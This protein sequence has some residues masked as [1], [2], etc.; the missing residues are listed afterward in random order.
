M[1]GLFNNL[2]GQKTSVQPPLYGGPTAPYSGGEPTSDGNEGLSSMTPP[3]GNGG[4][5]PMPN[6]IGGPAPGN[7]GA[8]PVAPS[9][10]GPQPMFAGNGS[11]PP[12]PGSGGV[13][14][15]MLPGPPQHNAYPPQNR[16]GRRHR[17]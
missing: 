1:C 13:A 17:K 12:M 5:P 11:V 9:S 3:F 10:G 16:G 8:P 15:P 6:G 4:G 14:P 7:G 2:Q